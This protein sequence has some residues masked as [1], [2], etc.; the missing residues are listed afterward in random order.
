MTT[1]K[2]FNECAQAFL[3][4]IEGRYEFTEKVDVVYMGGC[5]G[6]FIN[7]LFPIGTV[8]MEVR[9]C[10]FIGTVNDME[11]ARLNPRTKFHFFV[12]FLL[13]QRDSVRM[14]SCAL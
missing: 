1:T 14:V 13:L 11:F 3:D 8:L 10:G 12:L 5:T 6:T 9:C 2:A 4:A 7:E